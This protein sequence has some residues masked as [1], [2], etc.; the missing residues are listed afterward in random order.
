[1]SIG[2]IKIDMISEIDMI[3]GVEKKGTDDIEK[4]MA[5]IVEIGDRININDIE[6]IEEIEI[7]VD[8]MVVIDIAVGVEQESINDIIN[9]EMDLKCMKRNSKLNCIIH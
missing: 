5:R 3:C 1:M 7:E 2:K 8:H 6:Q 4:E 9:Q